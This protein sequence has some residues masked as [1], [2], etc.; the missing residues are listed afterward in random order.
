[1]LRCPGLDPS[2]SS[3]ERS[4]EALLATNP[5]PSD[6]EIRIGL[7]GNLCRCTGYA[8]ILAAVQATAVELN[9]SASV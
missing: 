2:W 1:M 8:R 6:E 7:S 5:D 3:L 9:G 4:G